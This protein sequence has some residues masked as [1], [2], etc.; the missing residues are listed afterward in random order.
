MNGCS[1]KF[2]GLRKS[3]PTKEL[4][5]QTYGIYKKQFKDHSC[6]LVSGDGSILEPCAI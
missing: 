6:N 1:S 4:C 3:L 5:L 2:R